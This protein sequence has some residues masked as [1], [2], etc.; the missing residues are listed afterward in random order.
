[1]RCEIEFHRC[2][3][4]GHRRLC[5]SCCNNWA[6]SHCRTCSLS[7]LWFS[8]RRRGCPRLDSCLENE[9]SAGEKM[10]TFWGSMKAHTSAALGVWCFSFKRPRLPK[11]RMQI[12][13]NS[14]TL[15]SPYGW[16]LSL[17]MRDSKDNM[18]YKV[19]TYL[20]GPFGSL[21]MRTDSSSRAHSSSTT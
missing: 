18:F 14:R 9:E 19:N 8:G 13:L 5:R 2:T 6:C 20:P 4:C 15:S 16:K 3:Y 1:M 17:F 10:I 7:P 12:F 11:R 21:W